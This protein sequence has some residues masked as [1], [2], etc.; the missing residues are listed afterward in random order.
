MEWVPTAQPKMIKTTVGSVGLFQRG[1]P[2]SCRAE[3]R[4]AR[5]EKRAGTAIGQLDAV[6]AEVTGIGPMR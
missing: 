5:S 3:R 2:D 1:T 4:L 6:P